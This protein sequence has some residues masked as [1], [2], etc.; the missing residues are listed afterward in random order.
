MISYLLRQNLRQYH[1]R[2]RQYSDRRD[3]DHK[4]QAGHRQPADLA[5]VESRNGQVRMNSHHPQPNRR[6][7]R[8]HDVQGLP[9]A[10]IHHHRG[11][12]RAGQLDGAHDHGGHV[13]IQVRAGFGE[14]VRRV[15]D[16]GEAAGELVQRHK[17]HA[18]QEGLLGGEGSWKRWKRYKVVTFCAL[19]AIRH[20]KSSTFI[21]YGMIF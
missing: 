15:V 16:E 21:H 12:V 8:R 5:D 1:K 19:E 6:S 13:R 3:E 18:D 7:K 2:Q 14:D 10:P 4:R 20:Q 17:D 11:H 9:L